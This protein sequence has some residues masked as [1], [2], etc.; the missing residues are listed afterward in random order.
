MNE[1]LVFVPLAALVFGAALYFALRGRPK[2]KHHSLF[3][4]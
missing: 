1:F 4:H 2:D 3:G